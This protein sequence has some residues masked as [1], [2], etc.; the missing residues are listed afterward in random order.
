[1][2]HPGATFLAR[3]LDGPAT[4]AELMEEVTGATQPTGNRRLARLER[5]GL[6]TRDGEG[7]RAPGR[8]WSLVH[9]DQIDALIAAAADLADAVAERERKQRAAMRRRQQRARA[10]RAASKSPDSRG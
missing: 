6:I 1:M 5:A 4:E 2:R 7:W 9:F 3:L 8:H 10:K